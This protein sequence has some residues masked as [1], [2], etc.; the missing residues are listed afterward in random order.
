MFLPM[1]LSA[2]DFVRVDFIQAGDH[3]EMEQLFAG[4]IHRLVGENTERRKAGL[5]ELRVADVGLSGGT[6]VFVVHFV[7][8]TGESEVGWN[9]VDLPN[10]AARFWM[11]ADHEALGDYQEAAIASLR[12]HASAI[13][14][15]AMGVSGAGKTSRFMAFMAG[16]RKI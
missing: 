9:G 7:L 4:K 8:S 15:V 1:T 2:L 5:A 6:D 16:V 13:D 12:N 14:K 3:P 11:G 10:V